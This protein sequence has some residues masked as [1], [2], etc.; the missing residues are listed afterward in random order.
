MTATP[1]TPDPAASPVPPDPLAAL[2]APDDQRKAA[3]MAQD[4]FAQVF[5]RSV[6]EE[7][8]EGKVRA[9]DGGDGAAVEGRVRVH[10]DDVLAA[11]QAQ[12][13]AVASLRVPVRRCHVAW[14]SVNWQTSMV[15]SSKPASQ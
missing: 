5:R 4:A 13:T 1:A 9:D 6:G 12:A 7:G 10:V 11:R 2:V 3:R 8:E 15:P 14:A